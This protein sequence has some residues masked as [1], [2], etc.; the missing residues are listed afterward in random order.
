MLNQVEDEG[1]EPKFIKYES[2]Y[3]MIYARKKDDG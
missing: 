3:F 2:G 1:Y